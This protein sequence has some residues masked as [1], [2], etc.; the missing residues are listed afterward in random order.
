MKKVYESI[1]RFGQKWEGNVCLALGMFDGVHRGHQA[2]LDL[3]VQDADHCQGAAAALTFPTHPAAF[4]RPG[5]EP[6]LLMSPSLSL[7]HI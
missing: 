7:I 4:L 5:K 3:V 1:A 6:S 2:V